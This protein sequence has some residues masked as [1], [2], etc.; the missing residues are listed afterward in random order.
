M[1]DSIINNQWLL[2]FTALMVLLVTAEAGFRIGLRLHQSKHEARRSQ[3]S[4]VQAAV[5]GMLGLLL[6]FTFAMGVI[7]F[8]L[9]EGMDIDD[10]G[11]NVTPDTRLFAHLDGHAKTINARPWRLRSALA[12][13]RG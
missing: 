2:I 7:R 8:S 9:D 4:G 1:V 13:S 11:M 6:G 3:I 10:S 5:L 12:P